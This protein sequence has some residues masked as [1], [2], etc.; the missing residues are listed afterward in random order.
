MVLIVI[1]ED[2]I[3]YLDNREP[4]ISLD[5]SMDCFIHSSKIIPILFDDEHISIILDCVVYKTSE[6]SFTIY[7][8]NYTSKL[9]T[10]LS[11]YISKVLPVTGRSFVVEND[12]LLI[13][14]AVITLENGERL[15]TFISNAFEDNIDPIT[16]IDPFSAKI[17][18]TLDGIH[19][20]YDNDIVMSQYCCYVQEILIGEYI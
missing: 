1:L 6:V 18:C 3:S 17:M 14:D 12:G 19:Y 20:I 7:V 8:S 9:L 2:V 11:R 13:L 5:I 15:T 4:N 16:L 10:I